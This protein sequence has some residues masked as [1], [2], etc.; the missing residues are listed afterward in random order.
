LLLSKIVKTAL[1]WVIGSFRSIGFR[2]GYTY[3]YD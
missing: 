3:E 1:F 2:M